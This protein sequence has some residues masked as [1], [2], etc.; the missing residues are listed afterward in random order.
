MP[1]L[2]KKSKLT[3]T[4]KS[5]SPAKSQNRKEKCGGYGSYQEYYEQAI[6]KPSD[7]LFTVMAH[8]PE[9]NSKSS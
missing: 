6:L 9:K 4:S 8:A 3:R 2:K 5:S 7:R 1:A